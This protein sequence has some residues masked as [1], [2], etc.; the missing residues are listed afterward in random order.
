MIDVH[1]K[2][3]GELRG[4][5]LK[6]KEKFPELIKNYELLNVFE[7]HKINYFPD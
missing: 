2:E 5:I 4:F 3:I 1:I 6:I 7:E